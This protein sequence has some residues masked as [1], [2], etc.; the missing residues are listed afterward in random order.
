M[1]KLHK[2]FSSANQGVQSILIRRGRG[3]LNV[4]LCLEVLSQ[5][6]VWSPNA[7]Y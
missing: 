4:I 7:A 3:I 5:S 6:E 1:E 2:S